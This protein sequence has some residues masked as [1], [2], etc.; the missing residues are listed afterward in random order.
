ASACLRLRPPSGTERVPRR[1]TLQKRNASGLF[2]EQTR[3]EPYLRR[4]GGAN[5]A[6]QSTAIYSSR[7]CLGWIS[8][9]LH[10]RQQETLR[11]RVE[12]S[13]IRALAVAEMDSCLR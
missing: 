6:R 10:P 7:N 8:N 1:A 2:S 13:A 9:D 4:S 11:S 12:H 5:L 3:T